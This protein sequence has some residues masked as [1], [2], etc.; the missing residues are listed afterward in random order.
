M[1]EEQIKKQ[2]ANQIAEIL[3]SIKN[4]KNCPILNTCNNYEDMYS[5]SFCT[6]FKELDNINITD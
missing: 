6:A 5:D 1:S 2:Q 4:C 3:N